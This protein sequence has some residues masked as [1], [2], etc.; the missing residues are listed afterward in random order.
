M[1]L[2]VDQNKLSKGM[3]VQSYGCI[4]VGE[5]ES[6]LQQVRQR[7]VQKLTI[8]VDRQQRVHV[9]HFKNSTHRIGTEST[10]NRRLRDERSQRKR[11]TF[12]RLFASYFNKCATDQKIQRCEA[13]RQGR[14]G[15]TPDCH[16]A[17]IERAKRTGSRSQCI[18]ELV[19]QKAQPLFLTG[20]LMHRNLHVTLKAEFGDCIC[21]GVVQASIQCA[22]LINGKRRVPLKS[23]ISD[24][25]TQ[26]T[27]VVDH[28][29]YR[30]AQTKERFAADA[31]FRQNQIIP[32]QDPETLALASRSLSFSA[33]SVRK[34]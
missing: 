16:V 18:T 9:A 29:I 32:A 8:R 28:L 5:L 19:S 10:C 22:K 7:G 4:C 21:D 20:N 15:S 17:H 27:I 26:I 13:A 34:N 24:C 30:V 14:T 23:Q 12:T 11:L 1:V 33:T 25:M 3:S 6:V 2:D 31:N